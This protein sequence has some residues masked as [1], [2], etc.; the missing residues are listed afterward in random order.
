MQ[1]QIPQFIDTEDK[2]VGPL[3]LREFIYIGSAIGVDFILFFNLK[4]WLWFILAPLA[5]G[6]GLALAYVKMNGR[7]LTQ[8]IA[9][10]FRYYWRPQIY[11]WQA[12]QHAS[13]KMA[14]PA[15]EGSSPL[16][17]MIAGFALKQVW[18]AV[19]TGSPA[20]E[21]G[22][23][24]RKQAGGDHYQIFR[25]ATGEQEVAKRIDYR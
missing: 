9:A 25:K 22:G 15:E 11:V 17:K 6:T 16:Q 1:F 18:R 21:T 12:E 7:R 20:P 19:S 24:P 2:I 10:A 3:T 4:L 8:I 5:L 13:P 14:R 23:V